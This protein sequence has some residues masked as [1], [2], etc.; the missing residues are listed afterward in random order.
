MSLREEIFETL[1]KLQQGIWRDRHPYVGLRQSLAEGTAWQL[2]RG[3]EGCRP[4]VTSTAVA[5]VKDPP[6]LASTP[7]SPRASQGP[8][9]SRLQAAVPIAVSSDASQATAPSTS[10]DAASASPP[11]FDMLDL[12]AAMQRMGF[13]R[14]ARC[15]RRWLE[16]R[17]YQQA[18]GQRYPDD[19]VDTRTITLDWILKFGE[20]KKRYVHLLTAAEVHERTPENIFN[21]D[22]RTLLIKKLKKLV[23]Q[24]GYYNGELDTSAHQVDMQSFHEKFHFQHIS[25]NAYHAQGRTGLF[26]ATEATNDLIATLGNF[27]LYAAVGRARVSTQVNYEYGSRT[28]MKLHAT[29]ELTHVYVYAR[30]S[31]SFNDDENTQTS[32][33][34]GH[35]GHGGLVVP[36]SSMLADRLLPGKLGASDQ[37][38]FEGWCQ[39]PS[40]VPEPPEALDKPVDTGRKLD[41]RQVYYPIRN[42]DFRA[43]RE[44]KGHGGDFLIFSDMKLVK[45]E[46]PIALDLGITER[47]VKG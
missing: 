10:T 25:V 19:M 29:A 1:L 11:P 13:S 27:A 46:R 6:P 23:E 28:L 5:M 31:Y 36:I 47:V 35:W 18:R 21:D 38:I 30:D 16:G 15:A 24:S 37:P 43:W 41:K 9:S 12:P 39:A 40:G 33:Y 45:L 20:V 32:Q 44:L 22:A 4:I 3:G 14:A 7:S 2:W 8:Q 42:R 34:L 26:R 17:A